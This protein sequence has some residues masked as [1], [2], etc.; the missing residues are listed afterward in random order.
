MS[1]FPESGHSGTP[2]TTEIRVRFRPEAAATPAVKPAPPQI[3]GLP[4][5][6]QIADPLGSALWFDGGSPY[7]SV[8]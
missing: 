2:K 4:E 7:C 5:T 6:E 8:C 1:A 3:Q